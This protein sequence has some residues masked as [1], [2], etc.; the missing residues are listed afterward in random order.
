MRLDYFFE[1]SGIAPGLLAKK[2]F[3]RTRYFLIARLY[4]CIFGGP[5]FRRFIA[6]IGKKKFFYPFPVFPEHG[7]WRDFPRLP[8]VCSCHFWRPPISGDLLPL[9]AKKSFFT[10]S[11]CSSN[12]EVGEISRD[13]QT[14]ALAIFGDPQFQ[15]I[16][17]H[18]WQKEVFL[19]IPVFPEHGSWRVGLGFVGLVLGFV[20]RAS[21]LRT[22]ARGRYGR[23][24]AGGVRAL[25]SDA[26][27]GAQ[28]DPKMHSQGVLVLHPATS[29]CKAF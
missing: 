18:Y 9:L 4:S 24:M 17:C 20:P 29:S 10:H 6:I 28:H 21:Q 13:C 2:I 15:A 5:H 23:A 27:A 26:R 7:S 3:L 14:S 19:P 8:D 25:A 12:T 16:Y 11:R 1:F 22:Q